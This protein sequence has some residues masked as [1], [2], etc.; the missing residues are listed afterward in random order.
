[1]ETPLHTRWLIASSMVVVVVSLVG[2]VLIGGLS[3]SP[4]TSR[5]ASSVADV[6]TGVYDARAGMCR[7][8]LVVDVASG[9]WVGVH[10]GA[11]IGAD[12]TVRTAGVR[13]LVAV[14]PADATVVLYAVA[15]EAGRAGQ[16]RELE[17]NSDCGHD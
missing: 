17:L 16:L 11:A 7:V 15:L 9:E 14:A 12:R 5:P 4:A 1:M 3:P 6:E 13:S 10:D 2:V 8:E